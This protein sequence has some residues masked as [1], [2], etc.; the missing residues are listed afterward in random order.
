WALLYNAI[1]IPIA[2]SGMLNPLFAAIAMSSS[3]LLVIW[4]SSRRFVNVDAT[5][6]IS[7]DHQS[8]QMATS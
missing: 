1:A 8:K 7:L 5:R 6:D 2:I 3:S 4:N